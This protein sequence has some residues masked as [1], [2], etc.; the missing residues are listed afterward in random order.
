MACI[1]KEIAGATG[2]IIMRVYFEEPSEKE[3]NDKKNCESILDL[4]Q[5]NAISSKFQDNTFDVFEKL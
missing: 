4:F 2:E 5:Y 3:K 1:N